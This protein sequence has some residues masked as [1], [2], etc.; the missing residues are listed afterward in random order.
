[1]AEFGSPFPEV[2]DALAH[3]L[4]QRELLD[5]GGV[6]LRITGVKSVEQPEFAGGA[7]GGVR[8]RRW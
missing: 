6:A 7:C 4:V 1:M 5:W 8:R 2:V 3:G